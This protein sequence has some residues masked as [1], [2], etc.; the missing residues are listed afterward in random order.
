MLCKN[1]VSALAVLTALPATSLA[2]IVPDIKARK[3]D[4]ATTWDALGNS[5]TGLF[6]NS[7]SLYVVGY[8]GYVSGAPGFF[9]EEPKTLFSPL[10]RTFRSLW[11][12][13]R[14]DTSPSTD[15][16]KPISNDKGII[17]AISL[18]LPMIRNITR[19]A[20]LSM[21]S[22]RYRPRPT[23]QSVVL[24]SKSTASSSPILSPTQLAR[25]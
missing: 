5:D 2:A 17:S 11:L 23:P 22:P 15:M 25:M 3:E 14:D 8:P 4:A 13:I 7:L 21:E 1:I 12:V 24:C 16:K 10:L 20:P 6:A 19:D 18:Y 9:A